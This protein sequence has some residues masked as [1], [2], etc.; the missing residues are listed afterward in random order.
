MGQQE[1]PLQGEAR[2]AQLESSPFSPQLE[3]AR[4]AKKTQH[5]DT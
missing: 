1:K 4:A 5:G 3:K 2:T